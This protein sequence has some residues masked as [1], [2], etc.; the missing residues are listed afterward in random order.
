MNDPEARLAY[1]HRVLAD[2]E[3]DALPTAAACPGSCG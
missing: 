2:A 1:Y 3:R